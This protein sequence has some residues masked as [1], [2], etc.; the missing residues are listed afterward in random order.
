MKPRQPIPKFSKK[1]LDEIAEGTKSAYP[2]RTPIKQKVYE[3]KRRPIKKSN[4]KPIAKKSTKRKME[5]VVY[6][7]EREK[8]L[9]ENPICQFLGCYRHATDLHHMK[10]RV[11]KNYTDPNYF[12]SLCR[13]HHTWVEENSK[14]AKELG[15]SLSRLTNEKT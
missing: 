1:R 4:A 5:E 11:G 13:Q 8:Y 14:E 15:Y 7:T 3:V 2:K 12:M 9:K 10:G 6:M